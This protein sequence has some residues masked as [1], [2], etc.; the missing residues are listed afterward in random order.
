MDSL[1]QHCHS[2][3]PRM[4]GWQ[5]PRRLLQRT[6]PA[7]DTVAAPGLLRGSWSIGACLKV[8]EDDCGRW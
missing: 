2:F 6:Q 5:R 3:L 4:F 1:T 8:Q 7:L